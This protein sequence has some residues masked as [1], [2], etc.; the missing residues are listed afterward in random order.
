MIVFG[1]GPIFF[2]FLESVYGTIYS[3]IFF[4]NDII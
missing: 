1:Y 4:K 2:F 3:T